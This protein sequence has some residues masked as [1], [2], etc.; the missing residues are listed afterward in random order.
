[1]SPERRSSMR[2]PTDEGKSVSSQEQPVSQEAPLIRSNPE[3][4]LRQ[5]AQYSDLA[6]AQLA[7]YMEPDAFRGKI[8]KVDDKN[9]IVLIRYAHDET[10]LVKEGK[11]ATQE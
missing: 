4:V 10:H 1:M 11:M 5:V 2:S 8:L 3:D 9:Q 6:P 7:E